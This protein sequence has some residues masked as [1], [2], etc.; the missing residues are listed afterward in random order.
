M[1]ELDQ[2]IIRIAI[3]NA[4]RYL[5]QGSSPTEAAALATPGAWAEFRS[6]VLRQLL[7]RPPQEQ[8]PETGRRE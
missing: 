4:R 2:A 3:A 1:R 5:A 8:A 6:K 7:D